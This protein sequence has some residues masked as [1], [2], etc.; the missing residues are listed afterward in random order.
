[1]VGA[2][3]PAR[4]YFVH[5]GF[6]GGEQTEDWPLYGDDGRQGYFYCGEVIFNY[7]PETSKPASQSPFLAFFFWPSL[8][9]SS[10]VSFLGLS[11]AF[12]DD[13]SRTCGFAC[14]FACLSTF[15]RLSVQAL[16]AHLLAL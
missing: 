15:L 16:M 3:Q 14:F 9:S 7:S 2:N 12:C 4:R 8:A 1:M 6:C 5:A 10:F 13:Q 11:Q